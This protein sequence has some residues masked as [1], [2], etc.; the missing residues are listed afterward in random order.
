M[1]SKNRNIFV[2]FVAV[3]ALGAVGVSSA[4]AALPEFVP[5][6]GESL[7]ATYQSQSMTGLEEVRL[8][9]A[10]LGT[11][12]SC[13]SDQIKGEI[14]GAKTASVSDKL[15]ECS[16]PG[17]GACETTGAGPGKVTITGT[18][19]LAYVKKSTKQV[20]LVLPIAETTIYC[21]EEPIRVKGSIILPI[22]TINT[23]T[24]S[25]E[26]K[27]H[28]ASAGKQEFTKYENEKNELLTAVLKTNP[29]TW[30]EAGLEVKP[31]VLLTTSK[32]ITVSA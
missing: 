3:F 8:Q 14:T 19:A 6:A 15:Q 2:A 23:K 16:R 11:E 18:A 30:W 31:T 32:S 17:I 24:T 13:H 20:A 22:T 26:M 10:Q 25:L 21:E 1:R 12:V 29:P 7:P 28:E 27:I 5:G 9:T 4:A